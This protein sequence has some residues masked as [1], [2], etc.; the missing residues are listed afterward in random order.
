MR[1]KFDRVHDVY[2]EYVRIAEREDLKDKVVLKT[3]C[4][5]E[6]GIYNHSIPIVPVMKEAKK[7]YCLELDEDVIRKA[8]KKT[9]DKLDNVFVNHGSISNLDD[10]YVNNTFDFIFDYSTIDHIPFEDLKETLISYKDKLKVGGVINLVIWTSD[11]YEI[12]NNNQMYFPKKEVD[13]MIKELFVIDKDEWL[14]SAG[15][16]KRLWYYR[17]VKE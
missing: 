8:Q 11:K 17:G 3:D 5:N 2:K 4:H 7:V 10:C 1:A 13:D 9:F 6:S 14:L 15:C 16:H 12:E